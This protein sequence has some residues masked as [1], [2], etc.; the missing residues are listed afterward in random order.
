MEK[1]VVWILATFT[2]SGTSDETP[3][4][5]SPAPSMAALA[6]PPPISVR[7]STQCADPPVATT[8]IDLTITAHSVATTGSTTGGFIHLLQALAPVTAGLL[9]LSVAGHWMC[10]DSDDLCPS[11]RHI[12]RIWTDLEHGPST[13][14]RR[15]DTGVKLVPVSPSSRAGT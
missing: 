15:S 4:S 12:L 10:R 3:T 6:S 2:S 1:S 13:A 5:F 8:V 7:Q 9:R 11:L 14:L